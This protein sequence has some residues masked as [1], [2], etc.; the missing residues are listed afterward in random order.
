MKSAKEWQRQIDQVVG[1]GHPYY[2]MISEL[3]G[4]WERHQEVWVRMIQELEARVGRDRLKLDAIQA[5]L[6]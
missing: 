1:P 5:L 3:V 2:A 4:D 6:K